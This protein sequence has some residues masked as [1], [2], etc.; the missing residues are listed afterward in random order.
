LYLKEY[1]FQ[2]L[3]RQRCS[4][5]KSKNQQKSS[6]KGIDGKNSK[7]YKKIAGNTLMVRFSVQSTIQKCPKN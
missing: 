2:G 1:K 7:N 5:A 6:K 4:Q 3:L